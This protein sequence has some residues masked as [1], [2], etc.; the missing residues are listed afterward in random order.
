M[1]RLFKQLVSVL[2]LEQKKIYV[3]ESFTGGKFSSLITEIPGASK[4]FELGLV[5]YSNRTKLKELINSQLKKDIEVNGP[6]S[7]A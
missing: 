6:T 2:T 3:V 1:S 7:M 5:T 4:V